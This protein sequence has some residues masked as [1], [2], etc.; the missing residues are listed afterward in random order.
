MK[1]QCVISISDEN[2]LK[3][4]YIFSIYKNNSSDTHKMKNIN[5]R[6]TQIL[7]KIISVLLL[8]NFLPFA[9]TPVSMV[10]YLLYTRFKATLSSF[11]VN[12]LTFYLYL[13]LFSMVDIKTEHACVYVFDYMHFLS[14][15]IVL[16]LTIF[17]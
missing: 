9:L 8:N 17:L 15:S 12:W 3:Y 7:L 5:T 10:Q 4:Y 13:C 6:L 14:L 11:S 16:H 1:I 2:E